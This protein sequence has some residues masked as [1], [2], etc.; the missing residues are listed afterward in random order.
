MATA[1]ISLVTGASRPMPEKPLSPLAVDV[2]GTLLRGDLLAEQALA[3]LRGNPFR[4]VLLLVW[5]LG[6]R[7][8]LKR[9]LA[10]R[11]E[12]DAEALPINEDLVG[13]I[14]AERAKGREVHIATASDAMAAA[15]LVRRF[16]FVD[17]LIASDGVS[18]L[19]GE[20]KAAA[21]TARFPGGFAY[22]GDSSADLPVWRAATESV[23]VGA[24]AST[25]KAAEAIRTPLA[26]IPRP[27]AGLKTVLKAARVHQWA[28][29]ALVFVPMILG[30]EALH[31]HTWG[32][33]AL[34]FLLLGILASSTY[35]L[36]DLWD[37]NDDRRH[38]SKRE[39]A[40]A[41]GRL[42]I[43]AGLIAAPLGIAVALIGGAL[44]SWGVFA[45]LAAYLVVTLAYSFRLKRVAVL[46]VFTLAALFTLRLVIGVALAGVVGSPWLLVFSMFIFSSLSFA[47]RHTEMARVAQSGATKAGGRG[48]VAADVPF[49]ICMGTATGMSAVL[50]M[51]LYIFNEAFPADMY[52]TPQALW[53]FPC[54]LFL[55]L[56]RVWVLSGRDE[57]HDDPVAFAVR[58][59]A[60][61]A[62]GGIMALAF[63]AAVAPVGR[64]W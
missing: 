9:R 32:V 1:P 51:V 22:A 45:A 43:A 46:D 14:E 23:V 18:N 28:K 30:G 11:V 16:S 34:G 27:K 56:G 58:D 62:L 35:V 33:V 53:V 42:P 7:A 41:S 60:S 8:A 6:G 36:N 55:W 40:F 25:L 31:P 38:W 49:L 17:G 52:R 64:F 21:L 59:R 37:L 24:S 4:I 3:F 26:V 54:V 50:V 61:I 44:I 10:E 19:K 47:K 13:F 48:Y 5:L 29:N 2:D 57:L 12:L 39:R 63:V 20:T 15:A